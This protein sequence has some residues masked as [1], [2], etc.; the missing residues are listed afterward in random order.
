MRRRGIIILTAVNACSDRPL[1]W[2]GPLGIAR[3]LQFGPA[4]GPP[5]LLGHVAPARCSLWTYRR[6]RRV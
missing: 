6:R 3:L 2:P 5:P 4:A 1:V